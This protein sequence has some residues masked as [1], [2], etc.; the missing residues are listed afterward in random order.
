MDFKWKIGIISGIIIL[1]VSGIIF[2]PFGAPQKSA[3]A[4]RFIVVSG[5]SHANAIQSLKDQGFIKYVF[6]YN[7]VSGARVKPGGYKISKSM[8]VFQIAS[9]LKSEPYMEWVTIPEGLRKEEVADMLAQKLGWD[10]VCP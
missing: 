1:I 2:N 5:E 8:N 4:E 10:G 9:V 7:L 6:A 3:E